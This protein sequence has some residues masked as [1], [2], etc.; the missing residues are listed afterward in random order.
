MTP[1]TKSNSLLFWDLVVLI[2]LTSMCPGTARADGSYVYYEDSYATE[3]DS[4]YISG[5]GCYYS[6]SY[7]A[8]YGSGWT[9][10]YSSA[11]AGAEIFSGGGSLYRNASMNV[12]AYSTW[13]EG[14]KWEPD[15]NDPNEVPPGGTVDWSGSGDGVASA[16]GTG[17]T[18]GEKSAF[19]ASSGGWAAST[20]GGC[21]SPGG[22]GDGWGSIG[23]AVGADGYPNGDWDCAPNG[24][25]YFQDDAPGYFEIYVT[26]W[27]DGG[28]SD[29][30]VAEGTTWVAG[31]ASSGAGAEA[32]AMASWN[33]QQQ[34]S[35]SSSS[36]AGSYAWGSVSFSFS[37]N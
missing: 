25:G 21:A 6:Y 16:Y 26:W 35:G 12:G 10:A 13:T 11:S 18:F 17:M 23:A 33:G 20:G 31:S 34:G 24:D 14:Y 32:E 36:Y 28:D 29:V 2:G 8:E 27:A 4:D 37:P 19:C 30:S 22:T 3:G 5:D 15:P 7:D 1:R 9:H